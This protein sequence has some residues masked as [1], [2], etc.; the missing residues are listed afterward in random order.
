MPSLQV[1]LSKLRSL[2]T[3]MVD[4][5]RLLDLELSTA[6]IAHV[7]LEKLILLNLVRKHSRKVTAAVCL[8]LAVKFNEV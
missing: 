3:Q 7:Y 1:T 5:V 4:I 2:K 6:A 8:L